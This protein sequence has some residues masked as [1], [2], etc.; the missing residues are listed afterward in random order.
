MRN[1]D[2]MA[3]AFC[4]DNQNN[5]N[6]FQEIAEK[7]ISDEGYDYNVKIEIGN[8]YFPTKAFKMLQIIISLF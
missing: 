1:L 3:K 2:N 6:T 4:F 7:T 8:F 5:I